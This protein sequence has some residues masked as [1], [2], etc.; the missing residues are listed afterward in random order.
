LKNAIHN[1]LAKGF[2]HLFTVY[3]PEWVN[4][5]VEMA[6][7]A[8]ELI[9]SDISVKHVQFASAENQDA[10]VA[11]LLDTDAAVVAAMLYRISHALFRREPKHEALPYLAQFM[12][13]RTSMEI[14]YSTEIGPRFKVMHGMG[15][16][17]GPRNRIGSDFAIYQGV[18]LGQR[19]F[20]CGDERIV[21]GNNCTLFAGAKVIGAITIGDHVNLAANAVLLGDAEAN[22]TYAG[23]PAKKVK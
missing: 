12:R 20:N 7:E 2:D 17:I 3:S 1:F 6:G 19:R 11:R 21:I 5:A 23:V 10:A 18:T 13:V 4:L 15:V 16:V 8:Q 14:Y 22:S 9:L